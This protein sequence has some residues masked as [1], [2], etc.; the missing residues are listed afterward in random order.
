MNDNCFI[1]G[2]YLAITLNDTKRDELPVKPDN[3]NGDS[4]IQTSPMWN[5][6]TLNYFKFFEA[7]ASFQGAVRQ[8]RISEAMQW[9]LEM[10]STDRNGNGKGKSNFWKRAII[11]CAEDI[12]LANPYM[13]VV[14]SQIITLL[15]KG[16]SDF[17]QEQFAALNM[18]ILLSKCAKSR[19]ADWAC[20]A[21]IRIQEPFDIITFHNKLIEC[22]VKGD[23]VNVY[24]YAEGF[25]TKSLQDKSNKVKDSLPLDMFNQLNQGLGLKYYKNVRQVLW[26]AIMRVNSAL[27]SYP[28]VQMIVQS[29]Y[30]LC[31][32]KRFRW[33]IPSRLFG[34]M[35]ILAICFRDKV[36]KIGLEIKLDESVVFEDK[37]LWK[38]IDDFWLG[39][40]QLVGVS[41]ICKDKHTSIGRSMGRGIQHFIEVKSFLKNEDSEWKEISD[42]YLSLACKTRYSDEDLKLS[43]MTHLEY[44]NW[45]PHLRKRFT[46]MEL[47]Y[48][49]TNDL[50]D[51][52]TITITFGNRAESYVGMEM[53]GHDISVGYTPEELEQIKMNFDYYGAECELF[54]L[55]TLLDNNIIAEPASVLVLRN[56]VSLMLNNKNYNA[57]DDIM[58]ELL[59]LDWDKKMWNK[60]KV[61]NKKARYN[62]VFDEINQ[63]P[64]YENKKGRHVAFDKVPHINK[65]RQIFPK[66][67]GMKSN[68]L[69]AEG[70]WYYDEN[71]YIGYHGDSERKIVIGIRLGATMNLYYQWYHESNPIG[72]KLTLKLNHGDIYIMSE[73]AIG[74]DWK[75]RSKITLRHAADFKDIIKEENV[76]KQPSI[77]MSNVEIIMMVGYPGCGKTSF[78]A[79][80]ERS[81]NKYIRIDGDL[82]KTSDKVLDH[83]KKIIDNNMNAIVDATNMSR[84][85]RDPIMKF[86]REKRILVK[87]VFFD[88]SIEEAKA[89]DK[90]RIN[91]NLGI[92]AIPDIAYYTLRKTF[93]R[94]E[95]HE[96]FGEIIIRKYK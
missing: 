26:I 83:L 66:L 88:F 12:S 17:K 44:A 47:T 94:P 40:L 53:V 91:Q 34:R 18:T 11:I 15:D 6:Y 4:A 75:C 9:C 32:H 38:F 68:N 37:N 52:Q 89:R 22:L 42:F 23:H 24:G 93:A 65:L 73:K 49:H 43:G 41:D 77:N 64:D 63:E 1:N 35:A 70:N 28:N 31:H 59:E 81:S 21:R 39:N 71:S 5:L 8:G 33:S 29:C 56:S 13:I 36:E 3:W 51:K 72:K 54:N 58:L 20:I 85:R 2:H 78:S 96:G 7:S 19:V 14:A 74:T 30:D 60:G 95:Y 45:L 79:E 57:D 27:N 50:M 87:C 48:D 62:I 80:I 92:K 90:L 86:A 55:N 46:L 76:F 67:F 82:L 16:Y 61:C 84:K 69:M 25:I 10:M